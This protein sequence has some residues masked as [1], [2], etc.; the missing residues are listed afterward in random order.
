MLIKRLFAIGAAGVAVSLLSPLL[1]VLT[2]KVRVK[3]GSPVLFSQPVLACAGNRLQF[4]S[5][6]R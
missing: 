3:L 2:L 1:A 4:T 6:G 5:S